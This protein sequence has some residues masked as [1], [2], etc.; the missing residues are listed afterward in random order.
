[1]AA[2]VP[3]GRMVGSPEIKPALS[4]PSERLVKM[5]QVELHPFQI[6]KFINFQIKTSLSLRG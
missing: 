3:S 1:M 4:V 6:F 5:R 2:F